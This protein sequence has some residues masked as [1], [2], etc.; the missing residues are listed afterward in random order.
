MQYTLIFKVVKNDGFIFLFL[1]K[2]LIVGKRITASPTGIHE[3][4]FT[5]KI[6]KKK[7]N[8]NINQSFTKHRHDSTR[9]PFMLY[10]LSQSAS[11]MLLVCLGLSC[12][13]RLQ[14]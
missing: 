8:T 5:A 6:R 12:Q 13:I 7:K 1:L 2:T 3:V 14:L 10:S 9:F 11:K 4:C